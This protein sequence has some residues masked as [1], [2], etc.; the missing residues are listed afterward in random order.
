MVLR[1]LKREHDATA[2]SGERRVQ[3]P[4][5]VA[6]VAVIAGLG[7]LRRCRRGSVRGVVV[8][9]ERRAAVR[10]VTAGMPPVERAAADDGGERHGESANEETMACRAQPHPMGLDPSSAALST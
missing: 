9:D 8:M 6:E 2:A 1:G 4:Q 7:G 5:R 10:I 3:Q